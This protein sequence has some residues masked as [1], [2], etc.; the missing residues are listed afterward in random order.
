M[1]PTPIS[2]FL[3]VDTN[4]NTAVERTWLFVQQPLRAVYS[5]NPPDKC[6]CLDSEISHGD[7]PYPT[8]LKPI[9]DWNMI[10]SIYVTSASFS[11]QD[12]AWY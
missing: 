12:N 9:A 8:P 3:W 1:S 2:Q 10:A 6:L 5:E 4:N 11:E 7:N